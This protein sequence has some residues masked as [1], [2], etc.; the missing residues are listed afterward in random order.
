MAYYTYYVLEV[1][2]GGPTR[3]EMVDHIVS[4]FGDV[5]FKSARADGGL[6]SDETKRWYGHDTH[7]FCVSRRWPDILFTLHGQGEGSGEVWDI[8]KW[9]KYYFDG[10]CQVERMPSIEAWKPPP[11]DTAKLKEPE[12][13][14]HWDGYRQL[15]AAD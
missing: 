3:D 14:G 13:N 4:V 10:K 9:T 11:F 6:L 1:G 8:D 5:A 2:E 7:M 15:R 12:D